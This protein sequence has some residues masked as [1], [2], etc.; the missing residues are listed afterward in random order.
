MF[1]VSSGREIRSIVPFSGAM[2]TLAAA[3]QVFSPNSNRFTCEAGFRDA[4][5]RESW[6]LKVWDWETG[7]EVR[8]ISELTN[9]PTALAFDQSGARLALGINRPAEKGG[10][11]LIVWD[12]DGGKQLLT[13]PLPDRR[14][15]AIQTLAFSPDGTRL[16]ALTKPAGPPDRNCAGTGDYIRPRFGKGDTSLPDRR[17]VEWLGLQPRWSATGRGQRWRSVA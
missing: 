10:A 17:G 6:G 9:W 13:V 1:D 12:V 7:R 5:G 8:S 4:A 15:E 16:A 14:W 2:V 3:P 11:D